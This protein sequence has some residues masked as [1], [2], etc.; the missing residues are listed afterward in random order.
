MSN[1]KEKETIQIKDNGENF[2]SPDIFSDFVGVSREYTD[3]NEGSYR[4]ELFKLLMVDYSAY[5]AGDKDVFV[6]WQTRYKDEVNKGCSPKKRCENPLKYFAP[7]HI[8]YINELRDKA[9]DDPKWMAQ[10][11][12][13][14]EMKYK[15]YAECL[16][17]NVVPENESIDDYLL[18]LNTYDNGEGIDNGKNCDNIIA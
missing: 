6:G 1:E 11:T 18:S 14:W 16:R 3:K 17:E 12:F 7:H 9:N 2:S 10:M 15:Y 8:E 5:F 13:A 4:V